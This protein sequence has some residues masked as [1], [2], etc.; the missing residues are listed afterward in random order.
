MT[1]NAQE[2][3][4]LQ[5]FHRLQFEVKKFMEDLKKHKY[6]KEL[7]G[8]KE[9]IDPNQLTEEVSLLQNQLQNLLKTQ[10]IQLSSK[11]DI[12]NS[13]QLHEGLSKKLMNEVETFVKQTKNPKE[14]DP[15]PSVTYEL[16]YN[17]DTSE[18]QKLSQVADLEKRITHLEKL[19]GIT[20]SLNNPAINLLSIVESLREKV[21]L[22]TPS[23]LSAIERKLTTLSQMMTIIKENT[24]TSELVKKANNEKKVD[25]IF[26]MMNQWDNS[27]QQL[28][29][30]VK[31]LITLKE[32]HEASVSFVQMM[33]QL[34]IKQEEIKGSLKSNEKILNQVSTSFATN[35]GIIKNNITGLEKRFNDLSQKIEDLGLETF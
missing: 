28:P 27:V 8:S 29:S 32:L 31:R 9:K 17:P 5:K 16:Y 20:E 13:A 15:K 24:E 34:E 33:Q 2:E 22:L 14:G 21:S 12:D 35:L 3:T 7:L 4:P 18:Y 10:G 19:I 11:Y 23:Q 25:E 30:I 26:Q 1:P 6:D